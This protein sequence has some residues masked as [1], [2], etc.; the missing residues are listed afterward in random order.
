M[1]EAEVIE[2]AEETPEVSPFPVDSYRE[3]APHLRRPFSPRAVKF[4]CQV[5]TESSA[6]MVA[7]IDARLVAERLNLVCPHLWADDYEPV[8][9]QSMMC[10]LTV[11]GITRRDVGSGYQGKGLYSDAFKRAGVKFGVGVSL[12]AMP[13]FWL[14]KD[15]GQVKIRKKGS[16]YQ[17]D[18]T[19]SGV[20]FCRDRYAAWLELEGESAFGSALD[21][22]D[23]EGAVGDAEALA[24]EDAPP[25]PPE[26]ALDGDRQ[27]D[28]IKGMKAIGVTKFRDL[29]TLLGSAGIDAL[30]AHSEKALHERL[31]SL[32]DEEAEKLEAEI[33]RRADG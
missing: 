10:L 20:T 5:V 15:N 6:M 14:S 30:R 32:S 1:S 17:A 11:D 31:A 33:S 7:Y 26:D 21:H 18:L 19:P 27:A 3:A 12:Y 28:L 25:A 24:D 13:A 9:T 16:K 2:A 23:A 29:D 4:K 8:G 22:G